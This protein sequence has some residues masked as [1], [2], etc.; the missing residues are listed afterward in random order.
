MVSALGGNV[1]T[2][3]L[4]VPGAVLGIS[5]SSKTIRNHVVAF[6]LALLPSLWISW[7]LVPFL[8]FLRGYQWIAFLGIVEAVAWAEKRAAERWVQGKGFVNPL[9]YL[10]TNC[11]YI[12]SVLLAFSGDQGFWWVSA[13]GLGLA[14][15]YGLVLY[16]ATTLQARLAKAPVPK[17]FS[18]LPSVLILLGLLAMVLMGFAQAFHLYPSALP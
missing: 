11:A 14:A 12:G 18:G 8:A 15:G 9:G 16:L 4:V 5:Q 1:L 6:L 17:S 13:K 2:N 7:A 3:R 10:T